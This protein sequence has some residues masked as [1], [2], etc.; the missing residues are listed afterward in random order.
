MVDFFYNDEELCG[1]SGIYFNTDIKDKNRGVKSQRPASGFQKHTSNLLHSK[2]EL[3]KRIL[4]YYNIFTDADYW[5]SFCVKTCIRMV[6]FT[7]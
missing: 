5:C 4:Q 1:K 7:F 6:I 2:S 3:R